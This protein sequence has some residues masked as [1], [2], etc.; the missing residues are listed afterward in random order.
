M[1]G[2]KNFNFCGEII[3]PGT[4]L[5]TALPIG[6][7]PMGQ[8]AEIPIQILH[9]SKTGPIISVIGAIHGDELNGTGIIHHLVYGDDH[10]PGTSDDHIDPNK[11]SGT[12]LLVPVANVDAMMMNSRTSPD[13]RDLNPVFPGTADGQPG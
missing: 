13:G 2:V 5:D 1:G 9:G 6:S 12:V 3:T 7:D 8:S 4:R 10:K 11:L